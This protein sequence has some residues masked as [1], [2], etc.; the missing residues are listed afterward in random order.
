MNLKIELISYYL[1]FSRIGKACDTLFH[2]QCEYFKLK[3]LC[4]HELPLLNKH[5]FLYNMEDTMSLLY[6]DITNPSTTSGG[7]GDHWPTTQPSDAQH[8]MG[9]EMIEDASPFDIYKNEL[10]MTNHSN[11]TSSTPRDE[12]DSP[13]NMELDNLWSVPTTPQE[14]PPQC[15]G[16]NNVEP[17]DSSDIPKYQLRPQTR[18]LKAGFTTTWIDQDQTGDYDPSEELRNARLHRNRVKLRAQQ[19]VRSRRDSFY[20]DEANDEA[21]PK[22]VPMLMVKLNF[23]SEAGKTKFQELVRSLP[24]EDKPNH[25]QTNGYQLRKRNRGVALTYN[26]NYDTKKSRF[27]SDLPEDPTG[28]PFARGCWECVA[29]GHECP[30]LGDETAWP[31][32]TCVADDNDCDLITAPTRKRACERCKRRRIGCSYSYTLNHGVACQQCMDDG[33]NCIAGPANDAIR[34]RIRYDRDWVNNP[35][36]IKNPP[37]VKKRVGCAECREAGNPCSFL[38]TGNKSQPCGSCKTTGDPCILEY[39]I[40]RERRKIQRA[41][42]GEKRKA[43]ETSSLSPPPSERAKA[44]KN[45]EGIHKTIET[46]L[47]HPIVFNC[48]E[49]REEPCHFCEGPG[50][51]ILGMGPKKVEVIEWTDGRGLDEISGGHKGDGIENTRM[52]TFCT[53]NRMSIIMCSEHEMRPIGSLQHDA[54]D[55]NDALSEPLTGTTKT[56]RQW[57]AICPDPALYQCRTPCDVDFNGCGL[58]LCEYCMVI[59]TGVHDGD[60]QKMLPEL[61]DEVTDE[62]MLGLRADYGL[63]KQDGLL[64]R[65]LLWSN[66]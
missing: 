42:R 10:T 62:K 55:I 46:K 26:D 64:M 3:L 50:Y 63:L 28:H 23:Q 17:D 7:A 40:P 47:C 48:D 51:G 22:V 53:M 29:L 61:K 31:C 36:S 4:K 30:L 9:D 32:S 11:D 38:A 27:A 5:N 14:D 13:T 57:C 49:K 56:S 25:V 18:E 24:A 54:T 16:D 58:M 20:E 45:C 1:W 65:Y 41:E 39:L 33:H 6:S 44:T 37:R 2:F 59:L 19:H 52:C 35:L 21:Q 60:L 43:D 15:D 12:G 8:P 66:Q 34:T